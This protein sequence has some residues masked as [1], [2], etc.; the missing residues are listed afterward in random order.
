M[1]LL[2]PITKVE[3]DVSDALVDRFLRAGYTHAEK[4]RAAAKVAPAQEPKEVTKVSEPSDEMK[5]Q[6]VKALATELGIR[7]KATVSKKDL[8]GMISAVK[9]AE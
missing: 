8:L 5:M 7:Y 1:K 4:P 9:A 3:V 6:E 2:D